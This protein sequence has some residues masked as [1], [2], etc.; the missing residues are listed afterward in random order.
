[1]QAKITH[2]QGYRCAPNGAR[3]VVFAFG[4]I[5]TGQVALWALDEKAAIPFNPVQETKVIAAP[6]TKARRGRK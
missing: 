5:V 3:V 4:E 2:P 1:M 6:E